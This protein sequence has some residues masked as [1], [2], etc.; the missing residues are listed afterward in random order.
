MLASAT[1]LPLSL[2]NLL[3]FLFPASAQAF[4]DV[5][6]EPL[7]P[8]AGPSYRRILEAIPPAMLSLAASAGDLA[9]SSAFLAFCV[10]NCLAFAAAVSLSFVIVIAAKRKA[11]WIADKRH[12]VA[13]RKGTSAGSLSSTERS[14]AGPAGNQAHSLRS[15]PEPADEA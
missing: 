4:Y 15:E 9:V 1:P 10:S 3:A 12:E 14:R 13:A 7:F 2:S 6:V 8:A 11:L 5:H